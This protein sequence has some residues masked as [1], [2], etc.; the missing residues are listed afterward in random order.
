MKKQVEKCSLK[1]THAKNIG[2]K[3]VEKKILTLRDFT[4]FKVQK[5]QQVQQ[6]TDAARTAST[7][8]VNF[9]YNSPGV[10]KLYFKHFISWI[11]PSKAVTKRFYKMELLQLY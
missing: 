3:T 10:T 4:P 5:M 11:P 6:A 1:K 9:I 7:T 2:V 8:K